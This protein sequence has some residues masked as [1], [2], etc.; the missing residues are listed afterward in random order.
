MAVAI[1]SRA[2]DDQA[3]DPKLQRQTSK[4][5]LKRIFA[6]G[7]DEIKIYDS[8]ATLSSLEV[9]T[10]SPTD[11]SAN[12]LIA[13]I[14]DGSGSSTAT[15][16]WGALK[17]DLS[18]SGF[19]AAATRRAQTEPTPPATPS[20][21]PLFTFDDEDNISG[22]RI[23]LENSATTSAFFNTLT[24]QINKNKKKKP[25]LKKAPVVA[26]KPLPNTSPSRPIPAQNSLYPIKQLALSHDPLQLKFRQLPS[27][28]TW[29]LTWW[30][31]PDSDFAYMGLSVLPPAQEEER[32]TGRGENSTPR[33]LLVPSTS[34]VY[35][36]TGVGKMVGMFEASAKG[37][38]D[39][40]LISVTN[41]ANPNTPTMLNLCAFDPK[42]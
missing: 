26:P 40:M 10:R 24:A 14:Q 33:K 23:T 5:V 34:A 31:I 25:V 42:F 41:E 29:A 9:A 15:L 32:I 17:L 16:Q 4:V 8:P 36:P 13:W 27:Q 37:E 12:L 11:G 38:S 19:S 28:N 2:L 21:N 6:S 35:S 1:A 20:D 3:T 39:L 22:A 18:E 7:K 30:S